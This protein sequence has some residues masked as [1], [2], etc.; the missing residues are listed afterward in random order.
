MHLD[1][2][3]G[4][5][6]AESEAIIN[7]PRTPRLKKIIPRYFKRCRIELEFGSDGKKQVKPTILYT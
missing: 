6:V 7:K 3:V 5:S 1:D 4:I 2:G